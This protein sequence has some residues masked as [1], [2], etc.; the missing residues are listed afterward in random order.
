[1]VRCFDRCNSEQGQR[2]THRYTALSHPIWRDFVAR[3]LVAAMLC[4]CHFM[5]FRWHRSQ[6]S[7]GLHR[8]RCD[9]QGERSQDKMKVA[10]HLAKTLGSS[11][12]GVKLDMRL[13]H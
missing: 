11:G 4:L 6:G 9:E 7:A 8:N 10:E 12:S 1:M 13:D 2:R 3:P 5:M